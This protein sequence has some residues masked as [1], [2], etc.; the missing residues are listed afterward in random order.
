MSP[1][2]RA[3]SLIELLVVIAIIGILIGLLLPAVQK[4][5]AAAART[6]CANNLKQCGLALD[7]YETQMGFYP[8]NE[9]FR[10]ASYWVSLLP[11]LEQSA[12][13]DY[14]RG[15]ELENEGHTWPHWDSP[16]GPRLKVLECP[17]TPLTTYKWLTAL[18]NTGK[19]AD[20]VTSPT[21]TTFD[22]A[23]TDYQGVATATGIGA[24]NNGQQASGEGILTGSVTY[25]IKVT[26]G[27]S[28]TIMLIEMAGMMDWYLN[29]YKQPTYAN[30]QFGIWYGFK[31]R[32]TITGNNPSWIDAKK[33]P[34]EGAQSLRTC[35]MNCNNQ[36][37]YSFHTGGCNI[38]FADGSVRFIQQK[39]DLGLFAALATKN[40][41]EPVG[42]D[43]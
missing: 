21:T 10:K 6:Q 42:G 35:A 41:G 17:A 36:R 8:Y 28:N 2:R 13:L 4:V 40:K 38:S 11:F 43:Y 34:S 37:A 14:Y 16:G 39:V 25:K 12:L 29:G 26:D 27:L 24:F 18:T 9:Q 32:G 31:V 30:N 1:N 33:Q 5:R 3:F 23:L 20:H 7:N 19:V 22:H 15:R